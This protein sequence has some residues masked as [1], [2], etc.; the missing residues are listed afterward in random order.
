MEPLA[1]TI[2]L[3]YIISVYLRVA[4][5]AGSTL[6]VISVLSVHNLLQEGG[7]PK[8]YVFPYMVF[9]TLHHLGLLFEQPKGFLM[10]F[11]IHKFFR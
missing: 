4:V 2:I 11:V 1:W 10:Q 5:G 9:L 3:V 7:L 8:G 6:C